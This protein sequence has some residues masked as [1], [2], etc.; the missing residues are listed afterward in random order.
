MSTRVPPAAASPNAFINF[1]FKVFCNCL[2]NNRYCNFKYLIGLFFFIK[3]ITSSSLSACH[4]FN[5]PPSL[6]VQPANA[7]RSLS[8][9]PRPSNAARPPSAMTPVGSSSGLFIVFCKSSA[10]GLPNIPLSCCNAFGSKFIT[11]T[12]INCSKIFL[13]GSAIP[14]SPDSSN[15]SPIPSISS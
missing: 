10:I 5:T 13:C 8:R 3:R 14:S 6:V 7:I 15:L 12:F 2:P 9:A 1:G 11:L 4:D